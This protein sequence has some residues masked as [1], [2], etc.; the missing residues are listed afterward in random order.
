MPKSNGTQM[1]LIV[2]MNTIKNK[3]ILIIRYLIQTAL[4][5]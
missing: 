5:V 1:T 4:I 2:M 3:T